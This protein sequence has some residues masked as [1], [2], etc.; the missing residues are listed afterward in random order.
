MARLGLRVGLDNVSS[1]DGVYF[2]TYMKIEP[3]IFS[4]FFSLIL[5]YV[6]PAH[7][8]LRAEQLLFS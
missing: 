6:L 3:T 1:A 8:G 5:L 7:T 2:V 4:P